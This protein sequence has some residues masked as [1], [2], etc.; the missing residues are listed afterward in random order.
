VAAKVAAGEVRVIETLALEGAKT[1]ALVAR[2]AQLGVAAAPTLLVVATL[3][4][5]LQRAARNVPW[6]TV[7]TPAHV[8]VYQALR[9][10]QLVFE[11]A[12]L[13]AMQ[14]ALAE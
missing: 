9:A 6:L 7:E 12:A 10:G 2:L 13:L 3:G 14:E 4:E 8:S 1:R 5:A 11:R